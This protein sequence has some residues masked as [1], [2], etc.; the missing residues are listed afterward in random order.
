[1]KIEWNKK[2]T[3][4]T[5]YAIIAAAIITMIVLFFLNI[6][7][8]GSAVAAFFTILMPFIVGFAIAYLLVRPCRF[9][10]SWNAGSRIRVCAV[11]FLFLLSS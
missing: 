5:V 1:M 11:L 3:T 2:Y 10:E 6:Q 8:F 4:I 9:V 7:F